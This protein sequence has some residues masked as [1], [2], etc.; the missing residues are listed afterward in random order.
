VICP[1]ES[2]NQNFLGGSTN[3]YWNNP[4][5]VQALDRSESG[6]K[7]NKGEWEVLCQLAD[8]V[9]GAT[10]EVNAQLFQLALWECRK[11]LDV[12]T[13]AYPAPRRVHLESAVTAILGY[14]SVPSG[15]ERP[16]L[17]AAALLSVLGRWSGR[18]DRVE[19]SSTSASDASTGGAGDVECFNGAELRLVAE[20]KDQPLTAAM[21]DHTAAKVRAKAV[22]EALFLL[23]EGVR[24]E[25]DDAITAK[26]L[27]EFQSGQNLYIQ[28][29][30]TFLAAAFVLLGEEGRRSFL[31]AVGEYLEAGHCER[32]HRQAWADLLAKL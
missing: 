16:E 3:P 26:V 14:I 20:V 13:V 22:G 5:R 28:D 30:S 15:G 7:K 18:F 9:E 32:I 2:Q 25:D 23:T 31:E 6:S 24:D 12:A 10:P 4:L 21:V 19:R 27:K 1:W 29:L 8:L 17:V 11:L